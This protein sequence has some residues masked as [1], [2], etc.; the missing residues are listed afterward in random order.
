MSRALQ[1]FNKTNPKIIS[2]ARASV[3]ISPIGEG[4]PITAPI[5]SSKSSR[6]QGPKSGS[7]AVIAYRHVQPVRLQRMVLAAEHD[8]D[9]GGVLFRRIEIGE[10]GDGDR[11]L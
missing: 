3:N 7:S 10:A 6:L 9:I 4:C 2:A 5:S 11:H 8:A 1:S